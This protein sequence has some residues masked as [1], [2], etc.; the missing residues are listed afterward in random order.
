MA[1]RDDNYMHCGIVEFDDTY[2]GESKESGKRG[3]GTVK[4]KVLVALSKERYYVL[5]YGIAYILQYSIIFSF[6]EKQPKH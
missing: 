4:I 1:Q 3:R 5:E 2:F 6:G